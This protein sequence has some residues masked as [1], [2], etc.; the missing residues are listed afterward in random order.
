MEALQETTGGAF[1]PHVYLLDGNNLVAYIKSGERVPFYFKNPIKGFD[2]RGRKFATITPNPFKV[3]TQSNLIKVKG[4][5]GKEYTVDPESKSCNCPGYTFR[6]ACKHVAEYVWAPSKGPVMRTYV[7][8]RRSIIEEIFT[9]KAK[10]EDEAL[11]MIQDGNC[12][13]EQG[14]WVDWHDRGYEFESVSDELVDFLN[15]K[16]PTS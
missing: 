15:S 16:N 4:S 7:F 10:S 3:N 11:E 8:T 14:E 9:V 13:V 6:G 2:K 12:L 5:N 1:H